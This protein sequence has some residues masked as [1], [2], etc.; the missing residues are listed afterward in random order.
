VERDL[1]GAA[2]VGRALIAEDGGGAVGLALWLPAYESATAERGGFLTDLYVAEA[3][4]GRGLGRALMAAACADVAQGG[5]AFLQLT[6]QARNARAR[7]FYAAL[8]EEE[9]G[10]VVFT[11][12]GGRF[13]RLAEAGRA[14]Q[15][16]GGLQVTNSPTSPGIPSG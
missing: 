2:P 9:T 4:R 5:G 1:C 11:A 13:A 16:A 12:A 8:C 15:A 14:A 6:A 7:A 3:W 10:L